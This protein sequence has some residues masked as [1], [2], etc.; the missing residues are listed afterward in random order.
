[1]A[2]TKILIDRLGGN[3]T[4]DSKANEGT[5]V[6]I[7]LKLKNVANLIAKSLK[8]ANFE[9]KESVKGIRVLWVQKNH[10]ESLVLRKLL[11][12]RGFLI[13]IVT[14]EE[15]AITVLEENLNGFFKYIIVD[16]ETIGVEQ[17]QRFFASL[18]TMNFDKD[19]SLLVL[20]SRMNSQEKK[21][22]NEYGVMDILF[23]PLKLDIVMEK[24][25][26]RRN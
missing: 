6:T 10:L 5:T 17:S 12:S 14:G 20:C 22:F 11:E 21:I 16:V 26:Y 8:S 13:N 1:M 2:I 7:D 15:E 25:L 4:V 9:S 3:I 24:L 19:V 18:K 23:K